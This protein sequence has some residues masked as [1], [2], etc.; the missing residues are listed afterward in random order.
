M[1]S[2][3]LLMEKGVKPSM[4]RIMIYDYLRG[5]K[6][7][8]TVDDIYSQLA[9]DVPTLSRTSVYNTVK[10]LADSGLS[11]VLTIEG[12]QT[13]Y[14]ADT[15]LHGHFLCTGCGGVSD[16]EVSGSVFSKLDGYEVEQR[17][18]YCSGICKNCLNEEN[19]N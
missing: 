19:K 3:T 9:A 1:D 7:H 8:P 11:K 18:I 6:S 10:I 16:F 4:L 2:K 15:S 14:D 17:E 13:R 5:T 12:H